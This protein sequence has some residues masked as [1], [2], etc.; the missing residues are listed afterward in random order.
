LQAGLKLSRETGD[1]QPTG[2][3]LR[4]LAT[5]ERER[6]EPQTARPLLEES[7][8]LAT[9]MGTELEVA[10]VRTALAQ[11]HLDGGRASEAAALA[12]QARQTFRRMADPDSEV[13]AT[14]VRARALADH[15]ELKEAS[16]A[17]EAAAG[18]VGR[19]EAVHP[20]LTFGIDAGY[21]E[22]ARGQV[23]QAG[24]RL[25][26]L[27]REAVERGFV[28]I[29][30]EARLLLGRIALRSGDA[31]AGPAALAALEQDARARGYERIA[32]LAAEA[33]ASIGR[34]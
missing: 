17:I 23:E 19:I 22:I 12:E 3:A 28:G 8:Q 20:R 13:M 24:A 7:L 32:R 27:R 6:G 11:L 25:D 5:V 30:L 15:G 16:G 29:E 14:G 4:D 10:L 33:R 31:V 26:K 1:K 21:V 9:E 34:G 2:V 18:L